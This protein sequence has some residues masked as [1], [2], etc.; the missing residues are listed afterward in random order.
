M[1]VLVFDLDGTLVSSMDDLTATLNAV[2]VEEGHKAI[3]PESVRSMVG[4]GAKVLLQRGLEA[5]GV[6]WTE[7]SLQPLYTRFLDYYEAHIAD[8]TRPFPGVIDA[9]EDFRAQGWRL[10]VCT[11]KVERL[12]LPLLQA[13]DMTQH[14]D[15]VVGGDTFAR[16]KPD[17]APVLGAI[18]RAGGTLEGSVMIGDSVTDID[19]ARAAGIPVIAVDFGYTPVPVE[20][21]G[22]DKVI[23]HFDELASAIATVGARA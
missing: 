14:F 6:T 23:S 1:S 3:A 5:N 20:Q 10:A 8:F 15:A 4:H 22:P 16:P 7:E 9:L 13:L 11:N 19:A 2:L 21:L 18:E 12:T 17:A